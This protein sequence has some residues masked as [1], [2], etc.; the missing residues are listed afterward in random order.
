LGFGCVEIGDTDERGGRMPMMLTITRTAAVG[1][2]GLVGAL[3]AAACG[4]DDTPSART[5]TTTSTQTYQY[6]PTSARPTTSGDP[7]YDRYAAAL[8]AAGIEFTPGL[9]PWA[10]YEAD[11]GICESIRK[12]DIDAFDLATREQVAG[13]TENGRRI[14]I[15]IP[16]VCPD[17]QAVLDEAL[18]PNP[19]MRTFLSGKHFVGY[20]EN[21]MGHPLVQPGTYKTGT[22]SDCYWERLDSQGNIIENNLVS[23]SQSVVVTIAESDAAFNAQNCGRWTRVD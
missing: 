10:S 16:I 15:M 11:K 8:N 23:L 2:V 5:T 13:K 19:T 12:G 22:V 6:S 18:G 1:A 3:G 9:E 17:Q 20:G 21:E 14:A 4:S 7:I